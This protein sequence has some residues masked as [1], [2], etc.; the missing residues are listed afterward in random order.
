MKH[1]LLCVSAIGVCAV[2]FSLP[3]IPQDPAYHQMADRQAFAGLPNALDVISNLP[4]AVVG[5]AG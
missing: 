5:G 1:V 2:A 4:F 3:P